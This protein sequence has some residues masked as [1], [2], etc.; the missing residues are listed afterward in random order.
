V[1]SEYGGDFLAV[2]SSSRRNGLTAYRLERDGPRQ[3]WSFPVHDRGASPLIANGHVYAIAGGANGH[4]ARAVCIHLDSGTL[5]WDETIDF[6]EVSSPVAADGK[7]LAISGTFLRVIAAAPEEYSVLSL[8]DCSV[9]LCT[10]P[11]VS[12]GRLFLRQATGV[13]CYDL[14]AAGG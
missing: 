13:I 10:S 9:T 7:I 2:L 1:A 4:D 12:D 11:A 14:R 8:S 3:L 6:A 5:A